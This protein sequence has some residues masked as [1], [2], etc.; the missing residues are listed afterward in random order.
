MS[1]ANLNSEDWVIEGDNDQPLTIGVFNSWLKRYLNVHVTPMHQMVCE[2]HKVLVDH[3][4]E[5]KLDHAYYKGMFK[6]ILWMVPVLNALAVFMVYW[7]HKIGLL[8]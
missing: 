7:L 6:A 1:H 5:E 4:N 2:T 8:F 3:V